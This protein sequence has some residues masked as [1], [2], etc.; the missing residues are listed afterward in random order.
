MDSSNNDSFGSFGVSGGTGGSGPIISSGGDSGEP[1]VFGGGAAKRGKRWI[2][3]VILGVAIVAITIG[4]VMVLMNGRN[5]D[6]GTEDSKNTDFYAIL[7]ENKEPIANLVSA[8]RY[9]YSGEASIADFVISSQDELD[10]NVAALND[11]ILALEKLNERLA[12]GPE[13]SGTVAETNLKENY[14][15]LKNA[16]SNDFEKYRGFATLTTNF[17]QVSQNLS[18][19]QEILS[20]YGVS[21]TNLAEEIQSYYNSR[22]ALISRYS[23]SNCANAETAVCNNTMAELLALQENIDVANPA[24]L[25]VYIANVGEINYGEVGSVMYYFDNLYAA[26]GEGDDAEQD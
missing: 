24:I 11:G 4:V 26:I 1:A 17:Y 12:S 2:W 6:S 8:V 15:G 3:A 13:L 5:G 14:E 19:A 9:I 20:E 16:V 7:N 23:E 18:S 10:L 22:A 25:Q 21:A